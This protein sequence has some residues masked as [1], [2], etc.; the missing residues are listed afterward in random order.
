MVTGMHIALGSTVQ[1]PLQLSSTWPGEKQPAASVATE[2]NGWILG[3]A[4]GSISRN[5]GKSPILCDERWSQVDHSAWFTVDIIFNLQVNDQILVKDH[6]SCRW[7]KWICNF[8]FS[9]NCHDSPTWY[10]IIWDDY[11]FQ[12]P[13]TNKWQRRVILSYTKPSVFLLVNFQFG[14]GKQTPPHLWCLPHCFAAPSPCSPA[15]SWKPATWP[16]TAPWSMQIMCKSSI[17]MGRFP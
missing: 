7:R 11:T 1:R 14:F 6:P 2:G 3:P 10:Q 12:F 9:V 4:S 8:D 13:S 15:P 16:G 5:H 17:N